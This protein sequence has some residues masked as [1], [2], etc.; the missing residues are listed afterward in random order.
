[1]T[2]HNTDISLITKEKQLIKELVGLASINEISLNDRGWDSRVY[3]FN[4]GKYFFKFPRSKTVQKHYKF[5][6][7]AIKFVADLSTDIV[8]QKILWEDPEDAYFGYEGVVG[9]PL[10]ELIDNLNTAQKQSIGKSLG[11]F[12]KQLHALQLPGAR[13]MSVE[14][15]SVQIQRWYEDSK[16]HLDAYFSEHEQKKLHELVY[17]IWPMKLLELGAESVLCHGDLHF[18]NLLFDP[19][20]KTGVIDFGDVAYYDRSKDFLELDI[21]QVVFDAAVTVYGYDYPH[22]KEKIATRKNMIQIINLGFFAGKKDTKNVDATVAKIKKYL[23][24]S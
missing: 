10:S 14:D 7:A 6:I 23:P 8:A 16:R 11:S 17:K 13:M 4:N 5:E 20:G 19:E 22:F 2:S 18:E 3:S 12:L 15:E 21:D 9:S 1:M 24:G